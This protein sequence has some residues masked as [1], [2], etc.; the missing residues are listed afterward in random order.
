MF[1]NLV[2]KLVYFLGD[3]GLGLP[4]SF[5]ARLDARKFTKQSK[6][7][8]KAMY[9]YKSRDNHMKSKSQYGQELF[10]YEQIFNKK[11]EGIFIEVGGN[12]PILLNNTYALEMLGWSGIAFE[13]MDYLRE[14]WEEKRATTCYPYAIGDKEGWIEFNEVI[15]QDASLMTKGTARGQGVLSSVAGYGR[16][17]DK[18][19]RS[20]S[21]NTV[22]KQMRPLENVLCELNIQHVDVMFVDVEGFELNVLKGVNFSKVS[23]ACICVEAPI[24]YKET[25]ELR[26]VLVKNGYTLVAHIGGD[27]IFLRNEIALLKNK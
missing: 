2:F 23:I 4:L 15:E 24:L 3:K 14:K 8:L 18:L 5:L 22:K 7:K 26:T 27:D 20:F 12:D 25:C 13:P 6:T 10:I 16:D 9:S 17:L 11:H 1:R 21:I 19:G